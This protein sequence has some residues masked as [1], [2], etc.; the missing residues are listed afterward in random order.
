MI[1][2]VLLNGIPESEMSGSLIR[3]PSLDEFFCSWFI[4]FNFDVMAFFFYLTVVYLVILLFI[5]I[6]IP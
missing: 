4:P 3:M 5:F 6:I 2:V 1:L